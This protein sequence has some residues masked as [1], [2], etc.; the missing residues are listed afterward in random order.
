VTRVTQPD[1]IAGLI[2]DY[3][4]PRRFDGGATVF[5]EGDRGAFV[6]A[7]V[8]GQVKLT[9]ATRAGRD[10]LVAVK[11]PGNSF[12]ELAA[13][14]GRARSAT[15]TATRDT[16]LAA[17]D[18]MA[19]LEVLESR[20]P[21][22]LELL[23][24]LAAYLRSANERVSASAADDTVTRAA[25]QLLELADRHAE[26]RSA[27]ARVELTG[28]RVEL[29]ITQDELAAWIGTTRE[30]AARA[31][32]KFRDAGCVTTRRGHVLITDIAKLLAFAA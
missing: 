1:A 5:R 15:A 14:D 6:Y 31:L 19:F 24:Q 12:G 18:G 26:H 8:D 17:L 28:A 21:A 11:R 29:T 3:G 16:V 32:A 30:S 7:V 27:G 25:R 4:A 22:A 23:R 9:V 20:P 13:L 10:V 2:I